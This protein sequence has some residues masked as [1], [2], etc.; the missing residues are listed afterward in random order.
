MVRGAP[1][2]DKIYPEAEITAPDELTVA[3]RVAKAGY[4]G[5]DPERVLNARVDLVM[6]A[7][8]Y[9]AF[10]A[11]YEREYIRINKGQQ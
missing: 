9:E 3:L 1:G 10:T 8:E 2:D 5:G 6:A 7:L 4:F 11:D